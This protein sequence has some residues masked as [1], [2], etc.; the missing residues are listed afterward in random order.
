MNISFKNYHIK[1]SRTAL[2]ALESL[3][4]A[5]EEKILDK[6]DILV[7]DSSQIDLKKL[8]GHADLYRIR[9]GNYRIVI[10]V[11]KK[12]NL[13]YVNVVAHRKNV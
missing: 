2:K 8:K 7:R 1:W 5:E 3:S 10:Q 4:I 9:S 11:S 13:V 6:L 12:E